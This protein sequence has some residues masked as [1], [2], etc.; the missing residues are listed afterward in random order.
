M[1]GAGEQGQDQRKEKLLLDMLS[2]AC[3]EGDYG[4]LQRLLEKHDKERVGVDDEE[5]TALFA[6]CGY[7]HYERTSLQLES[8]ANMDKKQNDGCSALF[9][10]CRNGHYDCAALL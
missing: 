8:G 7:G 10:A 9:A 1:K 5:R 3:S 4:L 6:A 2:K